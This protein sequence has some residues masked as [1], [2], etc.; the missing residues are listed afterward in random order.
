MYPANDEQFNETTIAKAEKADDGWSIR[1][2]DGWSFFVPR[3]SPVEPKEGMVARFYGRGIG[4]CV[5]GLFLDGQEV[6]YRTEEQEK[7]HREVESY[8]ADAA[9]WLSRWDEG[10]L[11]WS[12]SMGGFGP[13]YEQAIQITAAEI[14]RH[15]LERQYDAATWSDSEKWQRNRKEIESAGFA[16]AKIDALGLSGAQWGAALHLAVQLYRRGPRA[17]MADEQVKDRHIQVR[18]N[19][20]QG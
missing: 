10:R 1:R 13:G 9:D 15:L 16:N 4:F 11:V 20:S 12:I 3:T 6:Y 18:R 19:F 8:G 2:A 14:L 5:R 7:E 17:I